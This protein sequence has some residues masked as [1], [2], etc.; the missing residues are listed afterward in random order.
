MLLRGA[1][2]PLFHNIFNISLTS[3]VKLH[4]RLLYVVVRFFF[5][6]FFSSLQIW[7]VEISRSI[8]ESLLDFEITRVDCITFATFNISGRRYIGWCPD[9]HDQTPY[10]EIDL[11][12]LK[13]VHALQFQTT[14]SDCSDVTHKYDTEAFLASFD[15]EYVMAGDEEQNWLIY[16]EVG[17]RHGC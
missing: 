13:A 11:H 10:V 3:R 1:I 2:S 17:I 12:N 8:L 16:Y 7:Y 14:Y 4:N 5:F 9:P 6:F 15:L